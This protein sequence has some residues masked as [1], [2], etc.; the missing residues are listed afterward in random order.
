[1]TQA[2]RR[3]STSTSSALD[4]MHV[5]IVGAGPG[6]G[7]A[8]AR[9]FGR[10]GCTVTLVARRAEPLVELAEELRTVGVAVDTVTADAADPEGFREDLERLAGRITPGVVIYNAALKARDGVLTSDPTYLASAYA[11]DALGFI[12]CAQV[13]T[14]AMRKAGGGTLLA[15]GGSPGVAPEQDHASLS[16]G[17]AA[18]RVAVKLMH[19]ELKAGGV[20]VASVTIAGALGPGTPLDPDRVADLYWVLHTQPSADWSDETVIVGT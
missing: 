19:D 4:A 13:L 10:E 12:T 16:L 9:R 2:G 8:L 11:V 7:A 1:M 17:K 20:H 14:P 15:T 3:T 18:L 6:L 5:L